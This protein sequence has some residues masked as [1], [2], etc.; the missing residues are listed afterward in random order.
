MIYNPQHIVLFHHFRRFL[1]AA[2]KEEIAAVPLKGAHLLTSVYPPDRDRGVMAD[3]D[4]LV[5]PEHFKRAGEL[6]R[7][8]GFSFHERAYPGVSE[9][10]EA[11]TLQVDETHQILFEVHRYLF[12][13]I[14]FPID[15]EALWARSVSSH[16]DGAP[17]R[18]LA[19][20]DHFCHI[21]FH[22]AVH[23]LIPLERSLMDLELLIRN[24]NVDLEKVVVRAREWKVTRAV[25]LFIDLLRGQMPDL[26]PDSWADM[27]APPFPVRT[28]L[29]TLVQDGKVT[30]LI[31]IHHRLQAAVIWPVLFDSP[32]QVIRFVAT[33][34]LARQLAGQ[35]KKG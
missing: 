17:C 3:V 35:M 28:A 21:A 14:R 18:R 1:V 25:W 9:F 30:R 16:F 11:Y 15:H 22:A 7:K 19:P 6:L 29:R 27:L 12:E 23:R 24:G 5:R 4:F 31:D 13:P 32:A 10:E 33:H 2:A 34:P 20:E 26:H 8:L